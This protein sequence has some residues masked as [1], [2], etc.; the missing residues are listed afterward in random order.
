MYKFIFKKMFD[1]II[2]ILLV[3]VLIPLL[4]I[5]ASCIF[6]EDRNN[7][8]YLGERLGYKGKI[9]KMYKF[10]TMKINSPDI[11]NEDGSTFN[12]SVDPRL[13]K[14]GYFLR[15]TSLDE[16]PQVINV[17]LGQMSIVG[18]RPDLPEH[19]NYYTEEEV[20]KLLVLPGITGFNQAF[21][22]NSVEWK[23]RLKNDVFYVNNISFWMDIKI[24]FF[25]IYSVLFRKN[26]FLKEKE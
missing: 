7:C 4:L 11:R 19:I 18:P 2:C 8:F 1:Y 26:I 22:R 3:P 21:Y 5:I 16:I 17:L 13:T 20:K 12:S 23:E 9:F 15:K 10:R 6:I 25:T 14:V 24:I